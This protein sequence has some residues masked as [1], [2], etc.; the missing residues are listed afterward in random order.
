MSDPISWK[1]GGV[2]DVGLKRDLN[3]DS[4]FFSEDLGLII[5]AD[6]MGGH[7]GGEVASAM[8]I[9]T[10]RGALVKHT[11]PPELEPWS[12]KGPAQLQEIITLAVEA[13]NEAIYTAAQQDVRF[14]GMGTTVVLAVSDGIRVLFAHVGDS[15][16]YRWRSGT[17]TQLTRDHSLVN[18]LVDKGFYTEEEARHAPQKNVITRALGTHEKVLVDINE[19]ALLVGDRYLFCSDGLSDLCSDEEMAGLLA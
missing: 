13:A 16:L 5:L 3:E 2:S 17:L 1:V 9:D 19:S 10:I 14:Q 6:G 7:Q 15:R 18:E 11:A 8:A 4:I 12:G